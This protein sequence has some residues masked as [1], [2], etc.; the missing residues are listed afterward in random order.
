VYKP[1]VIFLVAY[2]LPPAALVSY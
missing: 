1:E 2:N